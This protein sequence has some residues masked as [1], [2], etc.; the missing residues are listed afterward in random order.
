MSPTTVRLDGRMGAEPRQR[1]R[2]ALARPNSQ[3]LA[4][5]NIDNRPDGRGV[6]GMKAEGPAVV[7]RQTTSDERARAAEVDL[8]RPTLVRP[9]P[10]GGR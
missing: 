4:G 2:A 3:H 8:R 10:P 1:N 6:V 7:N 5:P 9:R